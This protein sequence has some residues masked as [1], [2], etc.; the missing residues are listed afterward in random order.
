[1]AMPDVRWRLLVFVLCLGL[2]GVYAA[3]PRPAAAADPVLVGAGD[4]AD[5]TSI[6]DDAT[7]KL[8]DDIAGT[9][10][11]AGDN[12]YPN[13][14]ASDY[15]NCYAPNWGRHKDRTRPAPGN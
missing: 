9:V 11:T 4:I 13:G 1:M 12:A 15:S 8:L 5:C 6:N 10:F 14:A 7:A 2:T 3:W